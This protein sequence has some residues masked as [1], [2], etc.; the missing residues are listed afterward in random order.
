MKYPSHTNSQPVTG[1]EAKK[2][3]QAA[4]TGKP[5]VNKQAKSTISRILERRKAAGAAR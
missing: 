4:K 2:L 1:K 3:V 5:L